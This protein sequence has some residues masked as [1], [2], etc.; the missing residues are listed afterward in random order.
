M[1]M[2]PGSPAQCGGGRI[3][4]GAAAGNRVALPS[5]IYKSP[6]SHH[7][8]SVLILQGGSLTGHLLFNWSFFLFF[9]V[10][11]TTCRS[12]A[13][14]DRRYFFWHFFSFLFLSFLFF[15]FLSFFSLN[16]K[17]ACLILY[18]QCQPVAADGSLTLMLRAPLPSMLQSCINPQFWVEK[19]PVTKRFCVHSLAHH[20]QRQT[21]LLCSI[22][23]Y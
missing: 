19:N 22:L 10:S 15:S 23:H 20:S 18:T 3:E 13:G 16:P 8:P 12:P 4:D 7:D 5:Y 9:F 17:A 14:E 21:A 1:E 11:Q 2:Q 6:A